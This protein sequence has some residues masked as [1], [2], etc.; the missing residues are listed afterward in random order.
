[1]KLRPLNYRF[2]LKNKDIPKGF[3]L[4]RTKEM[5]KKGSYVWCNSCEEWEVVCEDY[6]ELRHKG[7]SIYIKR[8]KVILK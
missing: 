3:V 2:D 5:P 6:Y 4:L 8:K 1:M 7:I